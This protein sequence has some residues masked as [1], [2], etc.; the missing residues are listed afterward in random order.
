[1]SQEPAEMPIFT[2]TYDFLAWLVPLTNHFPRA[3]RHTVTRRL[4]DATLNFLECV[5]DANNQRGDARLA[6]LTLAEAQLDKARF[7]LR[8]A[9]QWRWINPGQYE[10]AGRMLAEMGRLLGGWQ[11]VTRRQLA[12]ASEVRSR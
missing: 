3:H 8:L 6:Q 9:H 5:V 2:K 1:M 7:Y 11:K 4:L 10:H 12:S